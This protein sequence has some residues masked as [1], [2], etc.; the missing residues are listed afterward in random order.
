MREQAA[1][2]PEFFEAEERYECF[3]T[4]TYLIP[5]GGVCIKMYGLYMHN[6]DPLRACKKG[7]SGRVD[8]ITDSYEEVLKLKRL[9]DELDVYPVHLENIVEDMMS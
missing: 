4:E 8:C 6:A 5:E 7:E 9:I 2:K 3:I 1:L